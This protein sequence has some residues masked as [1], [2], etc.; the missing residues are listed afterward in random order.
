M[1]H[2][3]A[4]TYDKQIFVEFVY[5]LKNVYVASKSEDF[6]EDLISFFSKYYINVR[7]RNSLQRTLHAISWTLPNWLHY[8]SGIKNDEHLLK[9]ERLLEELVSAPLNDV[10]RFSNTETLNNVYRSIL[11]QMV[12]HIMLC[13]KDEVPEYLEYRESLVK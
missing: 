13:S 12:N 6:V 2:L 4:A 5:F 11:L 9:F 3:R 7:D 10:L 8:I 1:N